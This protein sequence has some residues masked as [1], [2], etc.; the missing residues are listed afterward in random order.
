MFVA[1]SVCAFFIELI[2]VFG[3]EE[4]I[5][6][7]KYPAPRHTHPALNR[8]FRRDSQRSQLALRAASR[9]DD[10][11][12]LVG[13]TMAPRMCVCVCAAGKCAAPLDMGI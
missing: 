6:T 3:E 10:T 12:R 11:A 13:P 4:T 2:F 7:R 1:I 9:R 5:K 8:K